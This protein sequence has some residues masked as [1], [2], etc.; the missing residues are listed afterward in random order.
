MDNQ[1]WANPNPDLNLNPDL[2]TFAKS[3][4]FGLDV[5]LFHKRGFG[6]G[7]EDWAGFG[8]GFEDWAGFGFG[9]EHC[10]ICP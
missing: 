8:F 1:W 4:G 10:W 3:G 9:F 7:F 5:K 6:F 2:T